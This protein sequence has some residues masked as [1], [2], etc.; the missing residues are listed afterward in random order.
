VAFS[1]DGKWIASGGT[2]GTV[3]VW[4]AEKGGEAILVLKGHTNSV[5]SVTFTRDGKRIASSGYDNTVRVWET[6]FGQEIITLKGIT[7]VN[8]V[9][10]SPDGE[11]IAAGLQDGT[12][13]VWFAPKQSSLLSQS[14]SP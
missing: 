4:D 8:G 6:R 5:V 12:I 10:W 9:A 7:A 14:T 13:N 11:R 2:D 1:P 3:R